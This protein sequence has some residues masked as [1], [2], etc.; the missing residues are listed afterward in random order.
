MEYKENVTPELYSAFTLTLRPQFCERYED[1]RTQFNLTRMDVKYLFEKYNVVAF[2]CAEVTEQYNI[3][4]HGYYIPGRRLDNSKPQGDLHQLRVE[5]KKW[6]FGH[7][8]YKQ[9]GRKD[10]IGWFKYITKEI[11]FTRKIIK[12]SPAII[13]VKIA[14][15]IVQKLAPRADDTDSDDEKSDEESKPCKNCYGIQQHNC[16]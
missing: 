8:L 3:H 1:P 7:Q 11:G 13:P 10:Y 2:I 14:N 15:T 9:R 4:Y 6:P 12:Q 5:L 16:D